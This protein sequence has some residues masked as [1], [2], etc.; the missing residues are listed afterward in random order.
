MTKAKTLWDCPT[1]RSG[2]TRPL[3]GAWPH[4]P[5]RRVEASTRGGGT[6]ADRMADMARMQEDWQHQTPQLVEILI[7]GSTSWHMMA[8]VRTGVADAASNNA[9]GGLQPQK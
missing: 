7:D 1:C 2:E 6:A 8:M 9:R 5:A 3:P 4:L